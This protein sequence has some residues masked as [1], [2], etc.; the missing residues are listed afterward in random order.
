M[1]NG[2]RHQLYIGKCKNTREKET[3]RTETEMRKISI[4]LAPS[5]KSLMESKAKA[6]GNLRSKVVWKA[7]KNFC[8]QERQAF[9][10]LKT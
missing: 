4:F 6:V 2:K 9:S 3:D 1:E 5:V 10:I 8:V 7:L